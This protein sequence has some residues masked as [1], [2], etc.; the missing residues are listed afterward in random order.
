MFGVTTRDISKRLLYGILYGCGH[1]K[2]GSIIDPQEK[3][4]ERLKELG[5]SAID[6]FYSGVPA[7]Q[8][9]KDSLSKSL[10]DRGHLLA[11]DRRPLYCRS[12]Y[13]ALNSLLQS[14]GAV[15]MKQVVITVQKNLKWRG[16]VYGKDWHQHAMI[17]DEIQL[18]C[19]PGLEKEIIQSV[20]HLLCKRV[21]FLVSAAK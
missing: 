2:A 21:T 10:T 1:I 14:A 6:S 18:S 12:E 3:D 5:R 8:E 9:L 11:L 20:C 16:L 7:L 17:H 19:R 15:L 4:P 13:Q